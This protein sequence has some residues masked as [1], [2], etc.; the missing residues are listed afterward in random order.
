MQGLNLSD[1]I[2]KTSETEQD[3]LLLIETNE[4]YRWPLK[5]SSLA[6]K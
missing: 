6:I 3:E 5:V 4:A 2:G 1:M